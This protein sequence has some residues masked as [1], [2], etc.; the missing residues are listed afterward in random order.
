M[1]CI[2]SFSNV[3]DGT[4]SALYY[5]DHIPGLT[6][7]GD[8]HSEPLAGGCAAKCGAR[9]YMG[10]SYNV[11][12]GTSYYPCTFLLSGRVPLVLEDP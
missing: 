9:S 11:V 2:L 3:L 4:F 1:E 6:I 5:V 7:G 8:F 10:T 12:G